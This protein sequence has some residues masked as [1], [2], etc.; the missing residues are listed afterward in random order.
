MR[1]RVRTITLPA[2]RGE[3]LDRSGMALA[4]TREARDVYVDPTVRGRSRRR[5]R[6]DRRRARLAAARRASGARGRRDIRV[7]RP[8]GRPRGRRG[9]RGAGAAGHRL[10][11]GAEALLPGGGPRPAG[12]RLR[13]RRRRGGRRARERLRRRSSRGRRGSVPS[14]SR[15]TGCRSPTGSTPSWSRYRVDT[16]V[17]TIDRQMQF[18]VQAALERAV[19]A[20]GALGRHGRRDGP[21]HRRGAG[22]GDIPGLRPER[23]RRRAVR[24]DAQPRGDRRLRAGVGEQDHH[25]GRGPRDRGLSRS[26]NGS[27]CPPRCRSG[28]SRSTTPTCIRWS[29]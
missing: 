19:Q 3:I 7:D 24:G 15:P 18:M 5:G 22:D 27:E 17:T 16:M 6:D 23:V 21:G 14:S 28:P 4:V 11:R 1:Q 26:T 13:E 9:P 10:P 25:G 8:A 29:R 20:N 2:Q 12:A